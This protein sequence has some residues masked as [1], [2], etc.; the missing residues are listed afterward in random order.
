MK[1]LRA[2]GV[3]IPAS[4]TILFTR[5]VIQDVLPVHQKRF[6]QGKD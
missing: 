2:P 5:H 3:L 4:I 1:K 6:A